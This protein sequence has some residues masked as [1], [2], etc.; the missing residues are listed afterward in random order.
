MTHTST[1]A[2]VLLADRFVDYLMKENLHQNYIGAEVTGIE[3]GLRGIE[4]GMRWEV[5]KQPEY[6]DSQNPKAGEPTY[7]SRWNEYYIPFKELMFGNR[8]MRIRN[9]KKSRY[10]YDRTTTKYQELDWVFSGYGSYEEA[11]HGT[12]LHAGG[13]TDFDGFKPAGVMFEITTNSRIFGSFNPAQTEFTLTMIESNFNNYTWRREV[14][15][16]FTY[17]YT[18]RLP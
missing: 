6:D 12:R 8:R 13:E 10:Q 9:N 15:D 7:K 14:G 2:V 18:G 4:N 11:E 16:T 17:K 5:T 3:K 1:K